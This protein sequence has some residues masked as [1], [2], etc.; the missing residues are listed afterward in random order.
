MEVKASLQH[1]H[2]APRKVRLVASLIRGKTVTDAERELQFALRRS[3]DPLLKLLRS[4]VA[5][6][7]NNFQ[8]KKE[9]LRIAKITVDGAP[10]QKRMRPRAFGRGFVVR[11]RASHVLLVLD[12]ILPGTKRKRAFRKNTK[13]VV[14]SFPNEL[15]V[16]DGENRTEKLFSKEGFRERAVQSKKPLN[17]IRKVFQR[18]VV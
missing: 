6:A 18:K 1:L 13:P 8:L 3:A 2:M 7:S 12:E 5:N 15:E 14:V 16:R 17:V 11:H 4:A 10:M 9:N